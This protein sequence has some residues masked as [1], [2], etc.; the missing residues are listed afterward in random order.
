MTNFITKSDLRLA[1]AGGDASFRDSSGAQYA[2]DIGR[3]WLNIPAGTK[4]ELCASFPGTHTWMVA[5][6]RDTDTEGDNEV[7]QQGAVLRKASF[8]KL[9][10]AC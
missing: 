2:N 6:V 1:T 9:V 10:A 7:L 5:I 3:G 8:D 4:V